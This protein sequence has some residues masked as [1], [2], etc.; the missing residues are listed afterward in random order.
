[1]WCRHVRTRL[2]AYADGELSAAEARGVEE[3]LVRCEQCSQEHTDFRR[4]ARLT[5]T[6]PLEDVPTGMHARIM[7]S[8]AY[9]STAP[10]PTAIYRPRRAGFLDA[11]MLAGLT[12][13]T[14]AV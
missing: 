8:L 11:W 14:A 12:T 9:A 6:I 2:S 3:H 4:L 1:M 10:L 13:A 5:A 7:T